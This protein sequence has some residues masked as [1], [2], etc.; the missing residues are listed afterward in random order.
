MSGRLQ[1]LHQLEQKY[2]GPIPRDEL[3]AAMQQKS[4]W[5]DARYYQHYYEER[6][7]QTLER[8]TELEACGD[9]AKIA[10]ELPRLADKVESLTA[11]I[12]EARAEADALDWQRAAE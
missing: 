7:K 12:N 10:R 6:L 4:D 11:L 1:R 9:P 8:V 3:N 2:N 5:V